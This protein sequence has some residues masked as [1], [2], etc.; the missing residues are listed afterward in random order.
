MPRRQRI[1][2]AFGRFNPP[3]TGHEALLSFIQQTALRMSADVRVYPSQSQDPKKNPLPF[4]E[5]VRFLKML[6]PRMQFNDNTAIRTPIDALMDCARMGYTDVVVV[7]GSDRVESFGNIGKYVVPANS[8][9]YRKDTHIPLQSYQVVVV[10]GNRDED[11]TGVSGM[12]ASKQRANALA[13]DFP[14]FQQGVPGQKDFV[15]RALYTAVRQHMGVREERENRERMRERVL[16][17]AKFYGQGGAFTMATKRALSN[18]GKPEKLKDNQFYA[19]VAID[20]A[21]PAWK[22]GPARTP[23]MKVVWQMHTLTKDE[24]YIAADEARR[25]HP[26]ATISVENKSGKIVQVFK[27]GQ[28]IHEDTEDVGHLTEA[29]YWD[30]RAKVLQLAKEALPEDQL[31]IAA[32]V[33]RYAATVRHYRSIQGK[34]RKLADDCEKMRNRLDVQ[35]AAT[36]ST[37]KPPSETDRMKVRQSQETIALKQRQANELMAAKLRDVQQ[38]ARE[39]QQKASAPKPAS[40]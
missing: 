40:R 8:P 15:A 10:P 32:E 36:V 24:V 4:R 2:I 13:G 33:I 23:D 26:R 19:V 25:K 17:E 16:G 22:Q 9:K 3:T 37:P 6:F 5:K 14:A 28:P 39:Q 7:A 38:K 35:E 12:S 21:S 27:P 11:S 29:T 18:Y 34:L 31:L 20:D 1:V 30:I